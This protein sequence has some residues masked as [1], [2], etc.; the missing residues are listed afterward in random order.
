MSK[1]RSLRRTLEVV[2]RDPE[3]PAEGVAR[4]W[5]ASATRGC[6][7]RSSSGGRCVPRV[8]H[9]FPGDVVEQAQ[10]MQKGPRAAASRALRAGDRATG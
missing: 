3:M 6:A 8:A 5:E 4:I 1:Q 9:T 10:L 7:W 2:E